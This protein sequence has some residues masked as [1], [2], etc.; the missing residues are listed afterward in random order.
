MKK[1]HRLEKG[2]MLASFWIDEEKEE[3]TVSIYVGHEYATPSY[4]SNREK[5]QCPCLVDFDDG[6]I[7]FDGYVDPIGAAR[8]LYKLL[9]S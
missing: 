7:T 3:A 6:E 8:E 9:S 5:R 2:D 1:V 4:F